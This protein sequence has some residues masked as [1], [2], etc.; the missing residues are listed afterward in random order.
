MLKLTEKGFFTV[1]K[2]KMKQEAREIMLIGL[3]KF[4]GLWMFSHTY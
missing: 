3:W 2:I 4:L 1:L